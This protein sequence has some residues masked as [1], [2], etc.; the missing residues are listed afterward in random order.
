MIFG[1]ERPCVVLRRHYTEIYELQG[2]ELQEEV[3]A[4]SHYVNLWRDLRMD[5]VPFKVTDHKLTKAVAKLKRNKSSPDG[6]TAEMYAG[7][8]PEVFASLATFFTAL[9][10]SLIIPE[11]WTVASASLAPKVLAAACLSKFRAISCLTTARKLLGYLWMQTL[12]DLHFRSF[13]T[14]FIPGGHA[15]FGVFALN[16]AA[17]LSREW[18]QEVYVAQLDLKKAFDRVKHTAVIRALKLQGAS[19]QCVALICALLGQSEISVSLGPFSSPSIPMHRGLPQG[20]PES[21][22]LFVLVTDMVLRILMGR[23][24]ARGS[25]WRL[26]SLWLCAIC[27]A[28]DIILISSSKADLERMVS[29][30][31]AGFQDVGLDV[32]ADKTHW[33]SWPAA[34]GSTLRAG[35]CDVSWSPHLTFV[36]GVVNLAGNCGP[37]IDL[38]IAQAT[39][40][41]HRWKKLL[42]CRWIPRSRRIA[43][44]LKTVFVS[45]LWLAATWTPTKKQRQFL[46]SWGA[47]TAARVARVRRNVLDD[48]GQHWRRLHREGHRLLRAAGGGIQ[49]MRLVL[50]HRFAGHVAR[51]RPG[52]IPLAL[53]TRCLSWWRYHQRRYNGRRDGMHPRR[54][55]VA[56]WESQMVDVYGEVENEDITVDAG[57]ILEAQDRGAW[58]AREGAFAA[59]VF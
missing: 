17:E 43:L 32:G 5:L 38:R 41:F 40:V 58:K 42:L 31:I 18:A 27:Y 26:D 34:L 39:K 2:E 4:K 10:A 16:R 45:L 54:F 47:R 11:E 29:E 13:Q 14:G 35:R 24:E 59:R 9:M 7:L 20:A 48:V 1:E 6:L 55:K 15:A 12:P 21:P 33:T 8:P 51:L 28:D 52:E 36:G 49:S 57:W 25:G 37:A 56:R 3:A 44:L 22:L 30:T 23:W 46:D 50:L 53:R 19:L